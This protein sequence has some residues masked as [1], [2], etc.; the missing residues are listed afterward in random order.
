MNGASSDD[1]LAFA[2]KRRPGITKLV[3]RVYREHPQWTKDR[4]YVE[5]KALYSSKRIAV[6]QGD[7]F[8]EIDNP[9]YL[10]ARDR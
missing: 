8:V 2:E 10:A 7:T 3:H 6:Q 1:D 5:A 9:D 4:C